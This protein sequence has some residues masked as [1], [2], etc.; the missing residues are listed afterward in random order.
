MRGT[1]WI[2]LVLTV[3]LAGA[4]GGDDDGAPPGT[5]ASAGTS[6]A[7]NAGR[8]AGGAPAGG[9]AGSSAGGA[10]SAGNAGS[11]AG[12][13]G[14]SAG[15][16]AG[17]AVAGSGGSGGAVAGSAGSSGGGAAGSG[18]STASLPGPSSTGVP[19]GTKLTLL[20]GNL[21]V[22]AAWMKAHPT[23]LPPGAGAGVIEGQDI[24]GTV[25]ITVPGVTLRKC[26][27]RGPDTPPAKSTWTSLVWVTVG[28]AAKDEHDAV[29]IEDCE[30]APTHP[31]A[32]INGLYGRNF[33]ARR[34]NIHRSVDG[35]GLEYFTR[36][37]SSWVHDLSYFD[38]DGLPS[39]PDGT[40]NDA[41]QL[42]KL[43]NGPVTATDGTKRGGRNAIVG[44]FFQAFVAQ[45]VGTPAKQAA[46]QR[47]VLGAGF[48]HQ[49]TSVL[50]INANLENTVTDNWFDGGF[51]PVNG[52]DADNGGENLGTFARNRFDRMRCDDASA[53]YPGGTN[54]DLKPRL[55]LGF[56]KGAKVVTGAATGD[57]NRFFDT[58][59]TPGITPGAEV[60]VRFY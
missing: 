28:S 35:L 9:N 31:A 58:S 27:V 44:N 48:D 7:G 2:P 22:D 19:P 60:L 45:D 20:T 37:E 42:H 3:A 59:T 6:P 25:K 12:G 14:K 39:H 36:I 47:G 55:T 13:A 23:G 15:S 53:V 24:H 29:L 52:G 49:A 51:M 26:R 43:T 10:S 30:I 21:V 4:C 32:S 1:G 56:K 8:S 18:G 41:V 40:H 46:L 11:P 54:F 33:T 57:A 38:D 34:N 17:G 50:M 5:T 16:G